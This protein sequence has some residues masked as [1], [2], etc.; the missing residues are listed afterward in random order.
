MDTFQISA[1]V[2]DN[3]IKDE[4]SDERITAL[5]V[6]ANEQLNE[7]AQN[8]DIYTTFLKEVGAPEK[9]DSLILWIL[10]MSNEDI[11]SDYIKEFNKDFRDVIPVSDLADLLLYIVHLKKVNNIELDGLDYLLEYEEE[12]IEDMDRYSFTNALLYIEKSK[13]VPMEF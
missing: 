8:K 1:T 12:G 13:I 3:Y 9:I 6:Q 10:L 2:L 4:L 5:K 7:I 11:C